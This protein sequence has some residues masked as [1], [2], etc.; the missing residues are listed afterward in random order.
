MPIQNKHGDDMTVS[1][2]IDF[3]LTAGA[4]VISRQFRNF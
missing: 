4:T 1:P 3:V 2:D